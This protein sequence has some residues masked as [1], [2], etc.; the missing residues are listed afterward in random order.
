MK[1]GNVWQF[2]HPTDEE[3]YLIYECVKAK[4]Y[5]KVKE[6]RGEHLMHFVLYNDNDDIFRWFTPPGEENH[7]PEWWN[8]L[9]PTFKRD[10]AHPPADREANIVAMQS[11]CRHGGM[12]Y[13]TIP[14][15][16]DPNRK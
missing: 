6:K 8:W 1:F 3:D 16:P 4:D 12:L 5:A 7:I 2:E 15:A 13:A 14:S 11:N 10:T 9:S